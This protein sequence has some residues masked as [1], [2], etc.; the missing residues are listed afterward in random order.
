MPRDRPVNGRRM[1]GF[2]LVELLMVIAAQLLLILLVPRQTFQLDARI[3][4]SGLASIFLL[5][6]D[7]P[8]LTGVAMTAALT[9]RSPNHASIKTI[10]RVLILPWV[11]W[12]ATAVMV[13][14][15]SVTRGLQSPGWKFYLGLWFWLGILADLTFGLP[16]WWQLGTRFRQLALR[17]MTPTTSRLP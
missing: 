14:V 5:V 7:L 13:T 9:A 1:R 8:A 10:F 12:A 4:A 17:Q 16:A 15:W 3:R 2:S 6:L 11:L